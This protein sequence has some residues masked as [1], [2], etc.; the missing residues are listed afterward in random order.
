MCFAIGIESDSA[1]GVSQL[2]H[3]IYE[4]HT[5]AE[6][7]AAAIGTSE[8]IGFCTFPIGDRGSLRVSFVIVSFTA[9]GL[10]AA[11]FSAASLNVGSVA[12]AAN[13]DTVIQGVAHCG[14]EAD[15]GEELKCCSASHRKNPYV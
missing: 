11:S 15:D 13:W 9:V 6:S 8:F 7:N 5:F 4:L 10:S 12:V 2:T 3:S 14:D 1:A